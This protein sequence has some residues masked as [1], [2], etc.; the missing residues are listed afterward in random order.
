MNPRIVDIMLS[1]FN[2][3]KFQVENTVLLLEEG[4]TIPFIARYR[5]EQTG[6]LDEVQIQGIRDRYL[7]LSELEDRKVLVLET[8]EKAGKLTDDLRNRIAACLK[9][10]DLE[11]IYL[12]YRPKRRTRAT[13]AREKGLEPLAALIRAY[14]SP[15]ADIAA[16][17]MPYLDPEKGVSNIEEAL[18]GASDIL[19]EEVSEIAD[20]RKFVRKVY[21]DEGRLVAKARE[22][23]AGK[24]SKFMDY[25]EHAEPLRNVPSHRFLAMRRGEKEEV[26]SLN[27]MGPDE[28]VLDIL[29]RH[30]VKYPQSFFA[31]LM[32]EALADGYRR[33]LL[34]S[35]AVELMMESKAKADDEA[36]LVFEK[37][38]RQLLLLPPGGQQVVLG[39]DPGFRTGCK[40]AVVDGTGRFHEDA[41]VYPVEPHFKTAESEG[42]L[43]PLIKKYDVR[44]IAIGNGTGSRETAQFVKTMLSNA[45][46]S[47][48]VRVHVVNESGASVYSASEVAREEFPNLDITIRGAISIARRFQDP[49]AELVKI[50]PKSIGVG[51]YQHDVNQKKLQ[52]KLEE[53]VQ[54]VVNRVGVELNSASASL[55]EYVSG[56]TPTLARNIVERRNQSGPFRSRQELLEIP[57]FGEKTFQQAAGFLRIRDAENPLDGSAVHPERYELVECMAADL[58]ESVRW[59]FGNEEIIARIQIQNYQS[60]EVGLP[61]LWD[62]L[63]ELRKPGRDPRGEITGFDFDPDLKGLEDLKEGM[64]LPGIVTNVTNFGAF[65]DI[66][67]HQDGLVHLSRMGKRNVRSPYDVCSV[68]QRVSVKVV[69]VDRERKRIGLSLAESTEPRA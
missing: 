18:Q 50:T 63:E 26:L 23:W 21:A 10:Q 30:W 47:S 51:Q 6:E 36:I 60:E 14:T 17:C 38:L 40:V 46:L 39:V 42:V 7:Y 41:T 5:K 45:E 16:V 3:K 53:V 49:L 59:L 68:G 28:R 65:V 66:G 58:G 55:L 2:L 24:S 64:V 4:S 62:I 29:K 22:D 13:I 44:V 33:L 27:L 1:E 19:A 9:K 34:P 37:N 56:I 52:N 15:D 48:L 8:I 57:R 43:L 61:T 69:S 31:P 12:P 25:Y 35:I 20:F 54:F 67:V 11:D 32:A